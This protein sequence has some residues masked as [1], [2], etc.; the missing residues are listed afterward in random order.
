MHE[1][2]NINVQQ[3][4]FKSVGITLKYNA[5]NRHHYREMETWLSLKSHW[6]R[7]GNDNRQASDALGAVYG[8]GRC[9]VL[10]AWV[11]CGTDV[12]KKNTTKEKWAS[13]QG[14]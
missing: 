8:I 3:N 12:Q 7:I 5:P 6:P 2:N 4:A 1:T 11:K 10:F 14:T 13:F 9:N